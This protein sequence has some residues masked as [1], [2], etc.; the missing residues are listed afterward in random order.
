MFDAVIKFSSQK[1]INSFSFKSVSYTVL[2]YK[3]CFGTSSCFASRRSFSIH[4]LEWSLGWEIVF[5]SVEMVETQRFF[6][7]NKIIVAVGY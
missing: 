7:K 5:D 4:K 3:Q 2:P 6:L 1:S